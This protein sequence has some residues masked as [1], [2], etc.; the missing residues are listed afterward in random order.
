MHRSLPYS[1]DLPPDTSSAG[2][3]TLTELLDGHPVA[4][5]VI[6][7]EHIITHWNK[8]CDHLLGWRKEA[9]IG[10]DNHGMAFHARRQRMLSDLIVD[11]DTAALA[12]HQASPMIPGAYEDEAYF[13]NLGAEGHWLHFTAAPLH[14]HLGNK[15]GA[16]ETMRDVT[17]RR[18]AENALRRAHNNLEH[19]IEVRTAELAEANARLEA[20]LLQRHL[21][22]AELRTQNAKLTELNEKLKMAQQQ[23]VQSEKLASIGQLAA[24]VAHEINNPIGY[25]FSNFG[26]LQSY[27]DQ[28]FEIVDLYQ[29]A[30][31]QT[32]PEM[33]AKLSAAREAIDLDFLRQD[34]PVLM[35]ESKEG[36]ARV[37][38]IVQ[39]LKDFSRVDDSQEWVWACVHAGIDSTLNIVANEV[40][41]KA[42][43]HKRYGDL[44]DIECLPSQL[45]QVIMNLVVNAAHA[46]GE[47][48]GEIGIAT[49]L[50]ED[51]TIW[52]EVSDNGS[53]I[54]PAIVSRIFDPFFTTKVIGKGTGLGLSLSYGIIQK[55]RGKIE[56]D[57]VVGRGTTFRVTLPIRQ[58]AP[59]AG[60]DGP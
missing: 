44:P 45:N 31:A 13:P 8:A 57:S 37:R 11:G 25:I 56:V 39:D 7:N 6:D 35:S 42:D 33:A 38:H 47:A 18:V 43:V 10:T 55:H 58:S 34:I 17:E 20:D 21:A 5:F 41:Y 53:G 15:V 29:S 1:G 30:E 23:L 2:G 27:L 16:I 51:D 3:I 12:A 19:Q 60:G 50:G 9:M 22:D 26:T 46:I 52:I 32:A 4:T 54:E 59:A 28:L 24:G 14:D 40:K 36:I 48:R 49:G